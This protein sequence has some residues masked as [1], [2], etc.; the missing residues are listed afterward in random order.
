MS[1]ESGVP[2]LGPEAA[3]PAVESTVSST[4]PS[5]DTASRLAVLDDH[6]AID[7]A[8]VRDQRA[9]E[10]RRP[11]HLPRDDG[12][13]LVPAERREREPDRRE[14]R[15][16]IEGSAELL[17]QDGLLHEAEAG[18]AV[19]LGDRD[20]EPSE[21]RELPPRAGIP[22]GV[23]VGELGHALGWEALG[24]KGARLGLKRLLLG[25]EREVD[26]RLRGRPT[27]RSAMMLRRL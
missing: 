24:E 22:A 2:S 10:R 23:R 17:E 18:A 21:L 4:S 14:V 12:V 15:A 19:L 7:D 11:A 1:P 5:A 8:E 25:G 13:E 16:R 6:D 3:E 27:T 26:Q 20:A 9:V